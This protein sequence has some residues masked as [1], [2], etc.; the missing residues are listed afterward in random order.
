M[1]TE[2]LQN[3]VVEYLKT[4]GWKPVV[5]GEIIIQQ[6]PGE[7]KFNYEVVIKVTATPPKERTA[8]R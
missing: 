3:A 5:V 7:F 1:D 8:K 4:K 2:E 6:Q